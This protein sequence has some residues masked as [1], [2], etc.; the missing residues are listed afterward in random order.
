MTHI[1]T[2]GLGDTGL[3]DSLSVTGPV[4]QIISVSEGGE[5]SSYGD[6]DTHT[7]REREGHVNMSVY[8]GEGTGNCQ[9]SSIPL[10]QVLYRSCTT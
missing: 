9:A 10:D 4:G 6:V 8:R 3:A 1:T 5:E 2:P 7:H